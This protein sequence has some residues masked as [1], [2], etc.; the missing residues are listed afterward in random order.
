MLKVNLEDTISAIST[1]TGNGGIGI[2]RMSGKE[3]IEIADK[4]FVSPKGK[5]LSEQK[6]HTIHFG[7]IEVDG[8]VVDEESS[9]YLHKRRC[10]RNKYPRWI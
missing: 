8:K 6:S 5:K 1:A 2:V 9:K 7:T 3:A 4:L 10:S